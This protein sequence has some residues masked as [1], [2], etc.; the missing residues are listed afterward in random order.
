M[1]GRSATPS[2][3]CHFQDAHTSYGLIGSIR[4][5]YAA[6]KSVLGR[7]T[8]ANQLAS[9]VSGLACGRLPAL[10]G[11]HSKP[12]LSCSCYLS[13]GSPTHPRSFLPC[14]LSALVL[15]SISA[16]D[17]PPRT[18]SAFTTSSSAAVYTVRTCSAGTV[19]PLALG[20]LGRS[21]DSTATATSSPRCK[22]ENSGGELCLIM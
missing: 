4:P 6:P 19:G 5:T 22:G 12:V 9:L 20:P 17:L 8:D 18:L 7:S 16:V 15:G 11:V 21:A 14:T 2:Q 13:Q 3:L 10:V 1:I